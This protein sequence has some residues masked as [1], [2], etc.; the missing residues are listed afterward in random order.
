MKTF[1]LIN[2][3]LNQ[4]VESTLSSLPGFRLFATYYDGNQYS[5]FTGSI[6]STKEEDLAMLKNICGL[7]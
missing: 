5:V 6:L 4:V 3:C 2:D 7:E 1:L